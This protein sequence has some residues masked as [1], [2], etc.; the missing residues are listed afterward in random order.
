ML[1]PGRA[2]LVTRPKATGPARHIFAAVDEQAAQLRPA[3]R[4]RNRR[5]GLAEAESEA[6]GFVQLGNLWRIAAGRDGLQGQCSNTVKRC[7]MA[8]IASVNVG[9]RAIRP[10]AV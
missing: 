1:P 4:R 6:A 7:R 10:D 5:A 3:H 8:S 2:T 9:L